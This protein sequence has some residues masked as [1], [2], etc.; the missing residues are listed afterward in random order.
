MTADPGTE[1]E[2]TLG[3]REAL[4]IGIGTMVGAGI[5][6]FPGLA[7]SRAGLAATA[8]FAIGTAI[9]LLVALPTSELATAM[10]RS[11]GGY[12]FISRGLGTLAGTLV[13]LGLFTGLVF[14]SAFY[15]VGFGHYATQL[16][17]EAG[18]HLDVVK[19]LGVTMAVLLTAVGILGTKRSGNLQTGIV[20]LLLA[21]LVTFLTVGVLD[22]VGVFGRETVAE[23]FAPFGTVPVLTTAALVFTSYLGFAQIATMAG[24]IERPSRNLARAMV[25]SVLVVG[26]L[27]VLTVFVVTSITGSGELAGLGETALVEVARGILGTAGAL[28]VIGAGVLATV[29]SANASILSSSRTVY[30]LG[31]DDVVPDGVARVSKRFGTPHVSLV[32]AGGPIGA[33]VWFGDVELLAEVASFLHLVMYG[34]VCVTL[35]V[36]RRRPPRW[37]CPSF[38]TPGYPAVPIA[39]AVAS[40][41]L[42]A[43]M[44]IA[45]V[46]VGLLILLASGFWY[47]VYA[48]ERTTIDEEGPVE[49]E[50]SVDLDPDGV[51]REGMIMEASEDGPGTGEGAGSRNG[52]SEGKDGDD[53]G[54]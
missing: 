4:A 6:I 14:A 40:F 20:G 41:A 16:L 36:M 2:R 51:R 38:R 17:A 13:G 45:S 37:Y 15:L 33:L 1:L 48:R 3:L 54:P 27:Y 8:S 42:L 24:E 35:L 5:F 23:E 31:R 32:L 53:R 34:L 11:G 19:A 7:A 49:D 29:S 21:I 44:G 46:A 12:F 28:L 26:F 9:A 39:G 25:S 18:V 47:L 10:P 22:V 52:A 43:F 30:A 50:G